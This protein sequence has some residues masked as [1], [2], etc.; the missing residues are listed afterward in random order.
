MSNSAIEIGRVVNPM[1]MAGVIADYIADQTGLQ[2]AERFL[3]RLDAEFARIP[4]YQR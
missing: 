1:A 4:P 2:Q 3:S